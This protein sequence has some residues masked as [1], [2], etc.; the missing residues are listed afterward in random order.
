MDSIDFVNL[1][2]VSSE[3]IRYPTGN[4]LLFAPT[5][6]LLVFTSEMALRTSL[7]RL[8]HSGVT[9]NLALLP[10]AGGFG[11]VICYMS[12]KQVTTACEM[13][14]GT[15]RA[16]RTAPVSTLLTCEQSPWSKRGKYTAWTLCLLEL[17]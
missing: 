4:L 15:T 11:I 3:R 1:I 9:G 17:V 2:L 6:W 12:L 14:V 16:W 13:S 10:L 5:A 7:A 8:D